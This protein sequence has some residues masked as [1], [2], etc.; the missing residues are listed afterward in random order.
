MFANSHTNP[1]WII[2]TFLFLY[3]LYNIHNL[4]IFSLIFL[5][6][7]ITLHVFFKTSRKLNWYIFKTFPSHNLCSFFQGRKFVLN[8]GFMVSDV[9]SLSLYTY[10][11]YTFAIIIIII[12]LYHRRRHGVEN[13]NNNRRRRFIKQR[14]T[15]GTCAWR[16]NCNAHVYLNTHTHKY[17]YK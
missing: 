2:N 14:E 9:I 11:M 1:N 12:V 6:K 4:H 7:C 17:L 8:P 13:N 3:Y 15:L 10:T 16:D 5:L